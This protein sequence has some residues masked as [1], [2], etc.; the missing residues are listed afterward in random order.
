MVVY[1]ENLVSAFN[2]LKDYVEA[3]EGDKE[4]NDIYKAFGDSMGYTS[5]GEHKIR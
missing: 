3:H 2:M 1:I 5:S 4:L